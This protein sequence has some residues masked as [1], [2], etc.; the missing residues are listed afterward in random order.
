VPLASPGI[1]VEAQRFIERLAAV[2]LAAPAD[3]GRV[4]RALAEHFRALG[5]E[6]LPT[7]WAGSAK[8]G[9]L[10]AWSAE[11]P[12]GLRWPAAVEALL[13]VQEDAMYT[14][15]AAGRTTRKTAMT[16]ADAVERMA[17]EHVLSAAL[18]GVVEVSV[19]AAEAAWSERP[20]AEAVFS[21]LFEN[22]ASSGPTRDEEI[23]NLAAEAMVSRKAVTAVQAAAIREAVGEGNVILGRYVDAVTPFVDAFEAGLLLLWVTDHEAIAVAR[24]IR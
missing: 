24:P 10:A 17:D 11:R 9:F 19:S 15:R 1:G 5:L 20:Q 2:D 23:V 7:R 6:P 12:N 21:W 16:I 13:A 4:E 14:V 22:V 8:D 3:R 18:E